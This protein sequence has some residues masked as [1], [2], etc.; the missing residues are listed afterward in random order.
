MFVRCRRTKP[1]LPSI[2]NSRK[3]F[4]A[5]I[6]KYARRRDFGIIVIDGK[7]KTKKKKAVHI[8]RIL[9]IYQLPEDAYCFPNLLEKKNSRSHQNVQ[10]L[11]HYRARDMY[12]SNKR[13]IKRC[14][15]F[16]NNKL[17]IYKHQ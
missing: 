2:A 1:L 10:Y 12:G 4:F 7:I 13:I 5:A 11:T 6:L 17:L 9:M 8:S 14:H 3:L 15:Y 16:I